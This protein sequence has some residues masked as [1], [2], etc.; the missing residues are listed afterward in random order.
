MSWKMGSTPIDFEGLKIALPWPCFQRLE[1]CSPMVDKVTDNELWCTSGLTRPHA[2]VWPSWLN[3]W[4][5]ID[6]QLVQLIC[7]TTPFVWPSFVGQCQ[8]W[9]GGEGLQGGGGVVQARFPQGG[10]FHDRSQR[11]G[12][13]GWG[14]GSGAPQHF[15]LKKMI[16]TTC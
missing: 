2:R 9:G 6:V 16:A 14:V 11:R 7:S 1:H 12:R 10:G 15:Y 8:F 5:G 3:T 4:P 13:R